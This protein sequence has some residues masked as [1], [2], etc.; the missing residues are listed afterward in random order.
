MTT[1]AIVGRSCRLY[2]CNC[3]H[4]HRPMEIRTRGGQNSKPLQRTSDPLD[5][6]D[7]R[8]LHCHG[9]PQTR[10]SRRRQLQPTRANGH[11]RGLHRCS[12][13]HSNTTTTNTGSA[14]EFQA[15]HRR[16]A[17]PGG[18]RRTEHSKTPNVHVDHHH[19]DNIRDSRRKQPRKQ[20]TRT[21]GHRVG[22]THPN[23]HQSL[24]IPRKQNSRQTSINQGKKKRAIGE[25]GFW[26]KSRLNS[27]TAFSW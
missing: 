16:P 2:L 15:A 14:R 20:Q 27:L 12:N 7:K 25:G 26:Q 19:T 8:V 17:G 6:S 11:K 24:S 10:I 3:L 1:L 22:L 5:R 23:G 13:N 9:H 4:S 18:S 21:P